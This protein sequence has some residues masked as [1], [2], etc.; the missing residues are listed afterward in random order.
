[1]LEVL[2]LYKAFPLQQQQWAN[3]MPF[4]LEQ[5]GFLQGMFSIVN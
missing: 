2:E 3:E 1:M 4:L 5:E